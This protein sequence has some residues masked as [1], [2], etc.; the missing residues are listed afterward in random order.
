MTVGLNRHRREADY[1]WTPRDFSYRKFSRKWKQ[2][3][4]VDAVRSSAEFATRK[5]L[6]PPICH[7]LIERGITRTLDRSGLLASAD[8]VYTTERGVVATH[9]I[10]PAESEF[11]VEL[12]GGYVFPNTGLATDVSGRPIRES[13]EPPQ[14]RNNFVIETFVWHAFHDSPRLTGAL[15][16]N[17]TSTLDS[18]AKSIDVACPLCPR[19]AN[20]YHWLIETVPKIRYARAYKS[21]V[22]VDVTYLVPGDAPSWL[23]ETLNLLGV[24]ESSIEHATAAVYD[25][26]R[27]LI[28]SFPE[29]KPENYHWIRDAV[30]ES[31]SVD[32][33]AI[34]AG[35]NVF[36]SRA[37]AIERRVVNERDIVTTLREYGFEPYRLE[38]QTVAENAVLFNEADAV[39]GAHGAGLTDL[40]Y[41]D[42]TL[43][44][45]LFGS[46]IKDPYEELAAV[47]DVP[48]RSIQC[49]PDSTD[50]RADT[51][52]ICQSIKN[53]V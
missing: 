23:G 18:F 3:G 8:R 14:K 12:D 34:G 32:R 5:L 50:L 45:E 11:V 9:P 49:Q 43:I 28:P 4:A 1:M 47:V 53:I 48:Y 15:L 36:I 42:D 17:D 13:V 33:D 20:Y 19:F 6:A 27:L 52:Y 40:I 16:R 7:S 30:L 29:L 41:C 46:K 35:N 24:P 51:E 22:D 38:D 44:V 25:V 31:A 26:D 2:D 21:A 39:V 10:D 37:N